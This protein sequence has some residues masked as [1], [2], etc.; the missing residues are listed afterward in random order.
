QIDI[1][2]MSELGKEFY[3]LFC[4]ENITRILT[5]ESSGIAIACMAAPNFGVPVV[6]AKKYKTLNLSSDVYTARV[7]SFTHGCTYTVSVS[8]Q[9]IKSDDRVLIIDDFLAEGNALIGLSQIVSEAGASVSGIGI[10]IEKGFQNG[11]KIIRERGYNLKSLAIVDGMNSD[12]D[13]IFRK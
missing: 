9:Y 13:I 1:S 6:F 12:G 11:G 8:K 4:D 10:V 5:I 3:R 2:L 7:A